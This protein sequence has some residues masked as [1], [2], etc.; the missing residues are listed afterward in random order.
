MFIPGNVELFKD[1]KTNEIEK[2]LS[3]LNI[4]TRL[5]LK[6]NFILHEGDDIE[7]IGIILS[8]FVQIIRNDEIGNRIIQTGLGSGSIF[9]ESFVCAGIKKSPVAVVAAEDTEI[10]FI[11]F[12]KMIRSCDAACSFHYK[13][14]ENM[15]NLIAR[16][17][18]MLNGKIEILT[19]RSIREKVIEYLGQ[20]KKRSKMNTFIIPFSRN[21]LADYICVDRSALSRELGK[22][23]EL[24]LI[25][26]D[27]NR[28]SLY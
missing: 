23:K 5:I 11:P 6:G 22:M 24:G 10:L 26:V 2:L 7:S 9:A 16:K 25:S 19:K 12:N 4:Y 13:L 27:G 1:I 17:N 15:M 8:G 14:I 3:C 18:L 21:E 28:F 20:E